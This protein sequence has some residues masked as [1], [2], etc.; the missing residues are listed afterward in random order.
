[1]PRGVEQGISVPGSAS[2]K[3]SECAHGN[4]LVA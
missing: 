1:M 4:R 3:T 2:T